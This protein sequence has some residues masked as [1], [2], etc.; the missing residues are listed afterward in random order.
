MCIR[1]RFSTDIKEGKPE[2]VKYLVQ[3]EGSIP[4]GAT[5]K[6]AEDGTKADAFILNDANKTEVKLYKGGLPDYD[7]EVGALGAATTNAMKVFR[8]TE[9]AEFEKLQQADLGYVRTP[10]V[11]VAGV[12]LVFL[13]IFAFSKM[14][15]FKS[16]QADAPFLEITGR[17]FKRPRFLGGVIAQLFYVGAQIMCWTF[18]VHYGMEYVGLTLALSLIHI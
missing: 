17:I 8:E 11:V 7:T 10:Y 15:V 4:S 18:V 14:P 1:D 2:V 5:M 9:P 3:D 13:A 16:E 6:I 12:V